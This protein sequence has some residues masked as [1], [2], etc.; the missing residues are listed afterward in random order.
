M[1]TIIDRDTKLAYLNYIRDGKMTAV[2]ASKELCVHISTVHNWMKKYKEDPI[3]ALPG[4]G[5]Q[6]PSDAEV[7][8]LQKENIQLQA[9]LEF[10]KKAAAYFAKDHGKSMR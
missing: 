10:L 9:E 7:R 1:A 5:N 8:K 2:A 6:K 4:S 3:N